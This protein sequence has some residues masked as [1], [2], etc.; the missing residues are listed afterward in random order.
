MLVLGTCYL[1]NRKG[2]K[3]TKSEVLLPKAKELDDD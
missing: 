2:G 3:P 1:K